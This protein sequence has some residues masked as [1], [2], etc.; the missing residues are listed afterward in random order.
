[1]IDERFIKK[2]KKMW[3]IIVTFEY[4]I[5]KAQST[6]IRPLKFGRIYLKECTHMLQKTG[7]NKGTKEQKGWV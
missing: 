3:N 7:I 1:M 5:T 2:L 4:T 6:D